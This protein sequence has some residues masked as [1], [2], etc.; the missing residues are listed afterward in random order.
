[1]AVISATSLQG[2]GWKVGANTTCGASDTLVFDPNKTQI[3]V[4]YNA[5]VGALTPKIDGT[6]ANTAI[7]VAGY[8]TVSAAAGLTSASVAAGSSCSMVLSKNY[9]YMKGTVELTGA[10]GMEAILLEF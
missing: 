3:L 1:M 5:T 8:G 9:E 2:T 7:P 6:L 10:D 4:L